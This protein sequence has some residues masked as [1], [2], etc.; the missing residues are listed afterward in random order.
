MK[1]VW[2]C[3]NPV[4]CITL[5]A[6]AGVGTPLWGQT[7]GFAYVANCGN[8]CNGTFPGNV[9]AYTIGTTGALTEVVGSPFAA[10]INPYSVAVDPTGRFA[11]VANDGSNNVSAFTIDGVTGALAEIAGSPFSTRGA[12]PESVAVDSTGRFAYVASEF[13]SN[14]T[15]YTIDGTTG[16]LTQIA[17]SP[18]STGTRT[19]PFSVTVDPTGQF[20]YTANRSTDYVTGF[21]ID[22][23]T[24][25]LT[26]MASGFQAGSRPQSVT[27]TAGPTP[28][29]VTAANP[30]N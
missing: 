9:S 20:A 17:G 4:C 21:T 10:G 26:P 24:G 1:L 6:L 27:T 8:L 16:A 5:I 14:V 12:F 18:F 2:K 3:V 19:S 23:A 25:A 28:P 11:Y 22:G 29:P 7:G 30:I 13:H 15:A